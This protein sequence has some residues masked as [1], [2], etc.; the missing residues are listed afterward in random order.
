MKDPYFAIRLIRRHGG[1][2]TALVALLIAASAGAILWPSVGILSVPVAVAIGAL[3][4]LVLRSYVELVSLVFER[5][6]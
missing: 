6:N 3:A 4:F 2:G 1:V 5:L